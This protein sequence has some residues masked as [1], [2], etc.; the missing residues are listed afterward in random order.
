MKS[1]LGFDSI[2]SNLKCFQIPYEAHLGSAFVTKGFNLLKDGIEFEFVLAG[3]GSFTKGLSGSLI[4]FT[5]CSY[6]P[7]MRR[8]TDD[9]FC[10]TPFF[11]R[12]T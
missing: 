9:T 3:E 7:K 10:F 11:P 1:W 2:L 4:L 6:N 5:T 8:A 12:A